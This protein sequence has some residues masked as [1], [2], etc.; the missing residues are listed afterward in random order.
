MKNDYIT[1]NDSLPNT[2]A[3]VGVEKE[4][5]ILFLDIRNFTRLMETR[6]EQSVIQLVRYLFTGFNRIVKNYQ[7]RVVEMAG[8]SLYAVFG[9][10]TDVREAAN[11]AYMAIKTIFQSLNLFNDA[12]TTTY[13]SQP[14]EIGAGLHAGKVFI[15]EFSLDAAP[16]LSVMGLPVNVASRLQAK[17][18]ELNNDLLISEKVYSLLDNSRPVLS[19]Q[20]VSLKGISAEQDVRLAGKPYADTLCLSGSKQDMAYL[21]AISG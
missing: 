19:Q 9:L 15:G 8:D 10:Q 18:K 20:T 13:N 3:G 17:T 21:M 16:T 7:G 14:L 6:A 12:F 11:Q 1:L 5:A 4:L 2:V